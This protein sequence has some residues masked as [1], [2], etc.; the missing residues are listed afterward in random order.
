MKR[1]NRFSK[2][3]VCIKGGGDVASGVAWRLYQCGFRILITEIQKPLAVRRKVSFSEAVY[4][5]YMVVEGV[6]A[7]L[8]RDAEHV[9]SAWEKNKVPVIVDPTCE[10]RHF[11]KPDVLVDGILA[12]KNTGISMKDAPVTVAL[13]PGFVAGK[14]VHFVVET[15]R[16]H[17]LGRLLTSGSAQPDTGVP[18]PVKG[19]TTDRVL[20]APVEGL[21]ESNL[22]IGT[23]VKRGDVMGSVSGLEVNAMIDGVLRGLIRPG[24]HISK[25]LKIGDIDPRGIREHCNSISE[26]ALAVSGGVLEAILRSYDIEK[27]KKVPNPFH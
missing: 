11:V 4:E 20:R 6:E 22:Q 27:T 8:I 21:W 7:V 5:G 16:G 1:K 26:K 23:P 14:D 10:S 17:N 25:G 13:G 19:I 3:E 2:I 12:K 24:I 15:N 9:Y 18:G